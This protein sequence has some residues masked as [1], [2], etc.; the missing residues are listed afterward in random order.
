VRWRMLFQNVA[1]A[2]RPGIQDDS[3]VRRGD[4]MG[5][6]WMPL[7]GLGSSSFPGPTRTRSRFLLY[8][9]ARIVGQASLHFYVNHVDR[10][11]EYSIYDLGL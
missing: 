3:F 7:H 5:R 10:M 2:S 4:A 11:R 6:A 1:G 8:G 9:F